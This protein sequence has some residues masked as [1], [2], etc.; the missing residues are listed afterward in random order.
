MCKIEGLKRW[1][2]DGRPVNHKFISK[3][4]ILVFR[5][6]SLAD[7]GIYNCE[8]YDKKAGDY[9]VMGSSEILVGSKI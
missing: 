7:A 5:A 4:F 1:T 8:V 9:V 3:E 6:I 2:K